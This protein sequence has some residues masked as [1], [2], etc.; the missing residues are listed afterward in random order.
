[1]GDAAVD[2][3]EDRST[4][5][6]DH[7][8]DLLEAALRG[9][10]EGLTAP[11]RVHGQDQD[12]LE[13]VEQ[14][15]EHVDR[16]ARVDGHPADDP[17]FRV[18]DVDGGPEFVQHPVRLSSPLDVERDEVGTRRDERVDLRQRIVDHQVD[19][20]EDRRPDRTDDRRADR[21]HRA[22]HAVHHVDVD[23]LDPSRFEHA[24]LVAEVREVGRDHAHG[25][26]RAARHQV[27]GHSPGDGPAHRTAS[28]GWPNSLRSARNV[29]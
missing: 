29:S 5:G 21:Q 23:E 10:D 13:V 16:G 12:Q 4:R 25:Q 22:E 18:V 11:S 3:Q 17:P 27:I 15:L 14:G 24:D 1:V 26:P 20:L 8:S 9:R 7:R 2:A 19:V 28:A 6:I